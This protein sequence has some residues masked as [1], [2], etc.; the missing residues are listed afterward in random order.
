MNIVI[1]D[2][3]TLNPGD[4]SWNGFSDLAEQC[5]VY[6][7]TLAA[8]VVNRCQDCDI[9]LTNKTALTADVIRQLPQVKYIGVLA[10]GT[11]VVDVAFAKQQGIVVTNVPAYGPDAVA[12]MVF[13]HILHHSQHVALHDHAVKQGG[14]TQQRDFCFTLKP[15]M[16]LKGK[17]LG[18]VGYGD[19]AQQV[20]TIALAFGMKVLIHTPQRKKH[21]PQGVSWCELNELLPQAQFLSLHCPLTEATYR[22]IN[23]TT[24]K[25]LPLNA[26][27]INTARG[28]L[29]DEQALA[30]WL[31]QNQGY[32]SVDVLSTEPPQANNPL[33]S[34]DNVSITPHI[35]WATSEARQ[36]LMNIAVN[37]V[38]QY[39]N[40]TPINLV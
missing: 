33:L 11:N 14:W 25:A 37:N 39:I 31:N 21:L 6:E 18:L 32:A 35:A 2:G 19:I 1:L 38:V 4:L 28:D 22:M 36:N 5:Q 29:I 8:D 23:A 10:T 27:V 40:G 17:I 13:A 15:L 9:I 34:A 12:Q 24:L 26:M 3:Y 30:N 16:S 20:A 7:H